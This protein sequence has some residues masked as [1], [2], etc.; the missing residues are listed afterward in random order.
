[1]KNNK[2]LT[3]IITAFICLFSLSA[4]TQVFEIEISDIRIN[5]GEVKVAIFNSEKDW[6]ENPYRTL[7]FDSTEKSKVISFDI[8]YGIY[9]VSIYQ[10]TN[11]NDELD[12][13]FLGIPKEPIAFGNNYKPFGKPDFK[14]AAIEFR[15]NYK[16]PVLKLYT[17]L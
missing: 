5:K 11:G 3:P 10:D 13:N 2:M 7:T 6:L 9:A 1:M 12:T 8:P 15:S 16:I 14:S 4:K 17:I